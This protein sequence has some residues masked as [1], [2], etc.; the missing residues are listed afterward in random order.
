MYVNTTKSKM[1]LYLLLIY[2]AAQLLP[3]LFL[4]FFPDKLQI[5]MEVYGRMTFFILGAAGMI[6]LSYKKNYRTPVDHPEQTGTG[7]VILWGVGGMFLALVAQQVAFNLE[8]ILSGI[9]PESANT[10]QLVLLTQ[11]YPLFLMVI[12]VAGP[13]MEEYIFRKVF[14]GSLIERTGGIGAAVISSL[15]FAFFHMDGNLLVY[16][17]MGFAFCYVYYKTKNIAVPVIAHCLMN[18]TAIAVQFLPVKGGM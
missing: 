15:V 16:S 4:P 13:I 17:A 5:Y 9:P 18:L 11:N 7:R 8:M 14:F 10:Q 3:E 12:A 1:P 6:W 2:A